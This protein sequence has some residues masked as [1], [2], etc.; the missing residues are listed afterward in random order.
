M[1]SAAQGKHRVEEMARQLAGNTY[2]RTKI[3]YTVQ[4]GDVLGTIAARH[5]V[6]VQDLRDWNG[7]SG[8][9]IKTGQRLT[10]WIKP[11]HYGGFGQSGQTATDKTQGTTDQSTTLNGSVYYVQPGDTLW[12]IASS[13]R[14]FPSKK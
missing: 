11:E 13:T 5:H 8:N 12:K 7:L 10:L 1:D 14:V 4:S 6:R 2:G 3:R 9:L